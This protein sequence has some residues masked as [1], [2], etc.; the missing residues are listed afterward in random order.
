MDKNKLDRADR[1]RKNGSKSRGPKTEGGRRRIAAARTKHGLYAKNVSV[2]DVE[3]KEGFAA[4]RDSMITQF[5]P[6]NAYELQ[7]VEEMADSSWKIARLTLCAN[8]EVNVSIRHLRE[9]AEHPILGIDAITQAEISSSSPNGAQIVLQRRINALKH[10]RAL[11]AAEFRRSRE[12]ALLGRTQDSL[13]TEDLEAG[14]FHG[15][16]QNGPSETQE[17]PKK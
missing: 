16:S 6:R 14:F 11:A 10:G 3:S 13:K 4:L 9:S 7:L 12:V 1:S 17:N 8:N 2:L 15:T 5:Q